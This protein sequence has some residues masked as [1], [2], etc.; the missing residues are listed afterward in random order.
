[1]KKLRWVLSA[2]SLVI[3]ALLVAACTTMRPV[4]GS[5]DQIAEQVRAGALLKPGDRI[6][7]VTDSG[8]EQKLRVAGIR[9]DGTIVAKETEVRVDEIAS[10]EKREKSWIKTGVLVGLL[11]W[12]TYD[13]LNGCEGDP[14]GEYGGF[15]CCP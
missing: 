14:C 11:G 9:S 15:L 3:A 10:L 1:M 5:R 12:G 6:R 13:L 2:H 8:A 7:V 4:P